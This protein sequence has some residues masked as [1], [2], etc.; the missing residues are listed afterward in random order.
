VK[1]RIDEQVVDAETVFVIVRDLGR[2]RE[3]RRNE[4]DFGF[5][6][7]D[8]K[9]TPADNFLT[10]LKDGPAV[11]V[12]MIMWCDSLMNLQRT[13]DRNAIKEFELRVLFQMS[14]NDS[15]QLVDS[16]IAAKLGPQRAMFV[17][18]ETGTLE[19]F[20][21]YAFPAKEWLET[22]SAAMAQRPQGTP[23]ERPAARPSPS[24]SAESATRGESSGES[25]GLGGFTA[26]GGGGEFNFSK[27]L[28]D[29]PGGDAESPDG[30]SGASPA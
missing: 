1:R 18:E 20:R 7:G 19:K 6:M 10:I 9:A 14:G 13:F 25:G 21:P 16:P 22:V 30:D 8:K 27:M 12:H 28:D 5:S 24:R 23:V 15:S 3:L 4:G 26:F 17:H 2:F 11:G 29:L